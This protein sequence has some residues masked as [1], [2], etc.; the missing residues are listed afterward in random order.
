MEADF[1]D[2][3]VQAA[4]RA[5]RAAVRSLVAHLL[6]VIR[7][8]VLR[9]LHRRGKA[10]GRGRDPRQ[11]LD[12]L[13]QEVLAALFSDNARVLRSWDASRGLSLLN[14]V[15]LVAERQ[16]AATFRTGRRSPW[17]EDPTLD[18][19]LDDVA[20]EHTQPDASLASR[21]VLSALLERLRERLS[22]L[23]LHLFHLLVVD[24]VPVLEV[25]R[26]S[27]MSMDALY[28]WRSRLLRLVRELGT[29]LEKEASLSKIASPLQTPLGDGRL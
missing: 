19:E 1:S 7:A 22:P 25:S 14:F 28:A 27:N 17:T 2:E 8:R 24:E 16:V 9:A 26:T 3:M 11:E 13:T 23:G 5:D 21:E 20:T 15:G 10:Q 18:S 6:P 4:L 29:E 12:D